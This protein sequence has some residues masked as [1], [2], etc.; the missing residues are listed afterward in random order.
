LYVWNDHQGRG[1]IDAEESARGLIA[2]MEGKY[3]EVNGRW[4]DYKGDEIPW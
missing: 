3:G 2:A 4:C 1:L